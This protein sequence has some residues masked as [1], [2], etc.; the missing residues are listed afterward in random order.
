MA[1]KKSQDLVPE[2]LLFH[3]IIPYISTLE[4]NTFA[5]H[6]PQTFSCQLLIF[7]FFLPGDAVLQDCFRNTNFHIS[8][9]NYMLVYLRINKVITLSPPQCIKSPNN[10][11][12]F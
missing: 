8:P 11:L 4:T 3:H 2:H 10:K 9:Q 1:D 12:N 5:S 6:V 7:L